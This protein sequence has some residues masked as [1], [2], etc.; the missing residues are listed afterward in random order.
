MG[1]QAGPG[2]GQ[3]K[4]LETHLSKQVDVLPPVV[5]EIAALVVVIV[6]ILQHRILRLSRER[7]ADGL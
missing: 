1:E 3:K 4:R 2:N 5:I 7:E 6:I